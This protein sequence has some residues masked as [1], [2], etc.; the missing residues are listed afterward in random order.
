MLG[1]PGVDSTTG[2]VTGRVVRI[3][4]LLHNSSSDLARTKGLDTTK[5][6][7]R[8][9]VLELASRSL[10]Q[11]LRERDAAD[12]HDTVKHYLQLPLAHKGCEVFAVLSLGSQH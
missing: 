5:R 8:V 11:Q 10:A 1:P 7:K 2:R 4:R 12:S 6:S 9:A 3:A